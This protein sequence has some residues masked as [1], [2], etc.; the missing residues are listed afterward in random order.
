MLKNYKNKNFWRK[1]LC[2]HKSTIKDILINL[3][4]S[5]L[6]IALIHR[7]E[8]LL[9]TVTD[10][11][12]R[13]ALLANKK[14]SDSILVVLNSNPK[15]VKENTSLKKIYKQMLEKKIDHI[16]EINEK[17]KII[18]LHI[19]DQI[20]NFRENLFIIMAG[21]FGKRLKPYTNKIP[22]P[23]LRVNN[24]EIIKYTLDQAIKNNFS[25]FLITT[26]Y[27]KNL[28]KKYLKKNFKIPFLFTEEKK[29]LGTAGSL[30]LIT[31]PKMD[32]IVC[33]GDIITNIDFE[34]VL[35]FHQ[36]NNA[37]ATIV[38]KKIRTKNPYGEVNIDGL[39]INEIYEKKI[40]E[41]FAIAGIY[42]FSPKVLRYLKKNQKIDMI[43][44]LNILKLKKKKIIG[45]PAHENW[46]EMGIL[47]NFKKI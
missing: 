43:S 14:L 13:K 25:N 12:I 41:Q 27:K 40:T 34:E 24:K 32:F 29:P 17:K 23:L 6:K 10:G 46:I 31:K 1:A 37:Q 38:L 28:I 44:F 5:G 16:P 8:K 2:N 11:D 47:E 26:Y 7:N 4:K 20:K 22:K 9:G 19:R 45:F 30:S 35:N 15:T 21:G 42:V 3:H 33:N 36:K 39:K 18:N